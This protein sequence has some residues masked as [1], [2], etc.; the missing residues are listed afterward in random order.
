VAD[1]DRPG[2]DADRPAAALGWAARS[3]RGSRRGPPR[4]LRDLGPSA[5]QDL[6][7]QRRFKPA[8]L[9]NCFAAARGRIEAIALGKLRA[10]SEGASGL[11]NI[12]SDDIDGAPPPASA[13]AAAQLAKARSARPEPADAP[14]PAALA[15]PGQETMMQ[16]NPTRPTPYGLAGYVSE[17][18][19]RLL[20]LACALAL[21]L[22]LA[23][24]SVTEGFAPIWARFDAPAA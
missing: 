6:S 18:R 17:H 5:L 23:A 22:M 1:H 2:D 12:W 10:R 11:L 14:G 3:V 24:I 7:E 21:A 9:L 16:P 8:D 19:F 20:M 15:T 4:G 13:P